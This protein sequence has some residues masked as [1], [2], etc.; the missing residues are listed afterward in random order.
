MLEPSDSDDIEVSMEQSAS[1]LNSEPDDPPIDEEQDLLPPVFPLQGSSS[2]PHTGILPK[3]S[4]SPRAKYTGTFL[5]IAGILALSIGLSTLKVTEKASMGPAVVSRLSYFGDSSLKTYDT[6]N[7]FVL[8]LEEAAALIATATIER[9]AQWQFHPYWQ[10]DVVRGVTSSASCYYVNVQDDVKVTDDGLVFDSPPIASNPADSNVAIGD[11]ESVSSPSGENSFGT[12]NQVAGVD[13]ADLVKSDGEHVFAAYGNTLIVWDA[14]TGVELS[15]TELPLEDED[16]VGLC[17][18][19]VE[20]DVN[21]TCY[22]QGGGWY[23]GPMSSG[24]SSSTI[25]SILLY[26]NR[27]L[28]TTSNMNILNGSSKILNGYRQ[29]R[30]FLYD[31]S[32]IPT[33]SSALTL[34]ARKDLQGEFKTGRSIGQYGHIV[35]S[36]YVNTWDEL[37]YPL[38]PWNQV[39]YEAFGDDMTE[40]EYLTKAYEIAA[41]IVPVFAQKLAE[42]VMRDGQCSHVA[43]ISLMLQPADTEKES[44]SLPLFTQNAV[45]S[46][47]TQVYSTDISENYPAPIGDVVPKASTSSSDV[48]LPVPSYTNNIYSSETRIIVAGESYTENEIGEWKEQTVFLTFELDGAS[49]AFHSVGSVKGS[50]L[51]QFSMDHYIDPNTQEN[52][53][54][55]ATTSWAR[56]GLVGS[57]WQAIEESES[58]G[59]FAPSNSSVLCLYRLAYKTVFLLL[60]CSIYITNAKCFRRKL[61]DGDCRRSR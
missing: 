33:D 18:E 27:L 32:T 35:T 17:P 6:C 25:S 37:D 22:W 34:I 26:G 44:K 59:K 54:R 51:N 10:C 20:V 39:F 28:L 49:S 53:L 52:Y 5:F 55:V 45:L 14:L 24:T 50:L 4:V 58:I 9:N 8:D 1:F 56:W 29:T 42:E 2:N 21:D 57:D 19:N 60:I 61:H 36:S 7:D 30:M 38:S 43:K 3:G 47:L 15:R 23:F 46:T 16:G 48:F 31:I 13:E 41:D 12:N 11:K 40:T